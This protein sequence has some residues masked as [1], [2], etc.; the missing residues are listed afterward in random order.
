MFSGNTFN[1]EKCLNCVRLPICFG[2]CI[3]KYYETKI[4][5]TDFECLHEAAEI[6]LASYVKDKVEKQN[7]L[8]ENEIS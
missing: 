3:Q 7:K 6:S 1:N 2:P 8:L 5:K 4:G